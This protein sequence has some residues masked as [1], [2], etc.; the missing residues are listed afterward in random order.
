VDALDLL[1][2]REGWL[3]VPFFGFSGAFGIVFRHQSGPFDFNSRRGWLKILAHLI[4][5]QP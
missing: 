3:L 4:A 1:V 2:L 5:F